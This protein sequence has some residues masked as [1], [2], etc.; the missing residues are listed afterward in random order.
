MDGSLLT[1][2]SGEVKKLIKPLHRLKPE[3]AA[4][5]VLLQKRLVNEVK[6]SKA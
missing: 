4:V 5:L 6:C 2:L 1:H 3:E